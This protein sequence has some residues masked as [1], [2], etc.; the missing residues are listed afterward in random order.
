MDSSWHPPGGPR[1]PIRDPFRISKQFRKGYSPK[2]AC[3]ILHRTPFEDHENG[4]SDPSHHPGWDYMLWWC[5]KIR[6][7]E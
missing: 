4:F 1:G 3:K 5:I 2:F 7:R 6:V